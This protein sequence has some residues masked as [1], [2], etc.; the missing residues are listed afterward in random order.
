[1]RA[2]LL[3]LYIPIMRSGLI[4]PM[5][6]KDEWREVMDQIAETSCEAYRGIVWGE[7]EFVPYFRSAT[8]ERELAKLPLGSRPAKRRSD[9]GVESLRA[10]P[11]IFSWSQNRL[12]LPAWLGSGA[13]FEGLIK[14]GKSE[15]LTEMRAW[16][17]F[18]NRLAMLEMVFMKADTWLSKIYDERLVEPELQELGEKLRV[19]LEGAKAAI[20]SLAP[21][22]KL[23]ANQ[24]WVVESL[25]LRNPYIDP[26]HVLQVELLNRSR[27]NEEL[28]PVVDQALMVSI[29][30]IAAGMRNTG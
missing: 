25:N 7:E 30:G 17:F 28:C 18:D 6:P 14:E 2:A 11:W 13:A 4:P 23:L 27:A 3:A 10:I 8:P 26:L 21:D 5:E 9:G 16:P 24:A 19:K 12:L 1:M 22:N 29:A 20:V 15:L